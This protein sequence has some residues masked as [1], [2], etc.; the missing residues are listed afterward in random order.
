MPAT[1]ESGICFF[2]KVTYRSRYGHAA[3]AVIP[4]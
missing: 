2:K 1:A 4:P 3:I